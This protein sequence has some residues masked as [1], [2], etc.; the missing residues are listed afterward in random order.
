MLSHP[1]QLILKHEFN[2]HLLKTLKECVHR[3]HQ[4]I[5]DTKSI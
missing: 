3:L 2:I 1:I 4:G 5:H